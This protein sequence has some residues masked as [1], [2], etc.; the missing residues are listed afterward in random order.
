MEKQLLEVT[1]HKE[2]LLK[3]RAAGVKAI[4][5]NYEAKRS[6]MLEDFANRQVPSSMG[7]MAA[8]SGGDGLDGQDTGKGAATRLPSPEEIL[9]RMRNESSREAS[10]SSSSRETPPP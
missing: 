8:G 4:V 1:K 10:S 7:N 2:E 3:R 5:A 6:Q 9:Q